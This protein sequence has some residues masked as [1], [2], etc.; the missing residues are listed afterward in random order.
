MYY[1]KS[2]LPACECLCGATSVLQRQTWGVS[3]RWEQLGW[4]RFPSVV[5]QE[6]D[7]SH[8]HRLCDCNRPLPAP[9]STDPLAAVSRASLNWVHGA[10]NASSQPSHVAPGCMHTHFSSPQSLYILIP[11]P[12][13][14]RFGISRA[15]CDLGRLLAWCGSHCTHRVHWVP[16]VPCC[17]YRRV[18]ELC[19][20]KQPNAELFFHPSYFL[21]SLRENHQ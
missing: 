8:L 6:A 15:F 14:C 20:N 19:H 4:H 2:R 5:L 13:R 9:G 18:G 17:R 12:S 7:I 1:R 10:G 11:S 3:F 21:I 16:A